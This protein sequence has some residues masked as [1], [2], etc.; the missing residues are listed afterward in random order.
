MVKKAPIKKKPVVKKKPLTIRQKTYKSHNIKIGDF[1][2]I[3][4]KNV[5]YCSICG[6][7]GKKLYTEKCFEKKKNKKRK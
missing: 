6:T 4:G 3:A 7:H 1:R 5:K 2:P